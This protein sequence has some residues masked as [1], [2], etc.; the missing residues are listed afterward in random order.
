[1]KKIKDGDKIEEI[2]QKTEELSLAIQKVGA[3]LYKAAQ[4]KKPEDK[5]EDKKG[6]EEGQYKEK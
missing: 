3:E 2:K 4:E 1:L 6:P 5:S